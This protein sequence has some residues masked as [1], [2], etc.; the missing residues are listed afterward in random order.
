M[1]HAKREPRSPYDR[2]KKAPYRYSDIYRDWHRLTV[3]FGT[4]DL[5]EIRELEAKHREAM[6]LP[7]RKADCLEG[8]FGTFGA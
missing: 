8:T 5:P 3:K 4:N 7:P 2:Y 6:G 1:A